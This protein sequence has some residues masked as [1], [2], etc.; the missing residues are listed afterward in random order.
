[1][2]NVSCHKH[3]SFFFI[4]VYL[5]YCFP[6]LAFFS[7]LSFATFFF[8]SH[9]AHHIGVEVAFAWWFFFSFSFYVCIAIGSRS[10]RF[11]FVSSWSLSSLY[12]K[13]DSRM[14][15]RFVSNA[16]LIYIASRLCPMDTCMLS[17]INNLYLI[18]AMVFSQM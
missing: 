3:F 5:Q 7:Q 12:W 14:I 17:T 15:F 6:S 13:M 4:F 9:T 11:S 1:M 18:F 8:C 2:Y 16:Y 10:N